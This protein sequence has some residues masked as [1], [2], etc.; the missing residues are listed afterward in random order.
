MIDR[1]VRSFNPG[2]REAIWYI[3]GCIV[4]GENRECRLSF[5]CEKYRK[6]VNNLI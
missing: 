6:R 5:L 3:C 1:N 2:K 4:Q